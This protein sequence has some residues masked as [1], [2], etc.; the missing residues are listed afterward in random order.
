MIS[1]VGSVTV[2]TTVFAK[3]PVCV[4]CGGGSNGAKLK[5]DYKEIQNKKKQVMRIFVP[6]WDKLSGVG[7]C[8]PQLYIELLMLIF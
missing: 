6:P 4:D 1:S 2:T 7:Q 8:K 3:L 5:I